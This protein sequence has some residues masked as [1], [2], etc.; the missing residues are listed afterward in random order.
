MTKFYR[1]NKLDKALGNAGIVSQKNAYFWLLRM[2]KAGR[3]ICPRDPVT[4]Q[5]KLTEQQIEEIV[6]AFSPNG[7]GSWKATLPPSNETTATPVP[8]PATPTTSE[9]PTTF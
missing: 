4:N 9:T 5:R 2:E 1:R 6:R 3:I 8:I 7:S